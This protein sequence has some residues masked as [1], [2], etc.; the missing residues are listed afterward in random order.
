MRPLEWSAGA[1]SR[2]SDDAEIAVSTGSRGC[3]K[4]GGKPPH[5]K[6][7][8]DQ[9]WKFAGVVVEA[10]ENGLEVGNADV[11][12]QD[13]ADHR[14]KVRCQREVAAFIELVIV[15]PG[16]FAINL[17]A[18]HVAAHEEHA[19]R[20][21]VIGAAIAVFLG[22]AAEFAHGDKNNILHAVAH[23]LVKR[24]KPLAEILEQIG[25]LPLHA[26]FIDVIVPAAAIDKQNFHADVGFEQLA[27]LLQTLP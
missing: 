22:G 18:F 9:A 27:N 2:F 26:A 13:F 3:K 7:R 12:G 15:Q 5:S 14:A 25:K 8:A 16:P 11:F 20:V 17:P 23:V 4:S 21:A 6:L 1:C 19:I 24:P 10:G